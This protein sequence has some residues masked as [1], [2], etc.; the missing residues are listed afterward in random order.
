MRIFAVL[1]QFCAE[2]ITLSAFDQTENALTV[3]L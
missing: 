3:D 2:I 1:P